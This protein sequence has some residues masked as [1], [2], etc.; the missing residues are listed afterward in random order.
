[1]FFVTEKRGVNSPR[2]TINPPQIHR[3]LPARFTTKI[4]K[5]PC[6]TALHRANKKGKTTQGFGR[7]TQSSG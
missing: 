5:P 4:A 1:V 7:V 2:F 6:K 3:D